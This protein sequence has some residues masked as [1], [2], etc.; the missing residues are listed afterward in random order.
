[1]KQMLKAIGLL[2]LMS[3]LAACGDLAGQ[4]EI[5]GQMP[6]AVPQDLNLEIPTTEPDLALGAQVFAENCTRCHG[7]TGAGDGEFV[8][9]GQVTEIPIFADPAQHIGRTAAE[10]FTTISLGR[11]E[12]LMP[13][14]ANSLTVEERWSVAN[15]VFTLAGAVAPLPE[16]TESAVTSST[17]PEATAEP[18]QTAI[19]TINGVVTNGTAGGTIPFGSELTLRVLNMLGGES[20]YSTTVNAD[21]SYQF[22][23]VEISETSAYRV[24]IE[25]AGGTFSS[26]IVVGTPELPNMILDTI[27]YETTDDPTVLQVNVVL[28]QIDM[29]A[30]DSLQVWQMINVTNTSDKLFIG[31]N[32]AGRRVSV[33]VPVPAG[34][35]LSPANDL[36]RFSFDST[37]QYIYDTRP[38]VP[39]TE[40]NFH[41]I[42]TVPFDGS[43]TVNQLF[44]YAFT[45]PYEVYVDSEKLSLSADGWQDLGTQTIESFTYKGMGLIDGAATG[46]TL[47][48]NVN[49]TAF[50]IDRNMIGYGLMLLGVLFIVG[51]SVMYWRGR[52]QPQTSPAVATTGAPT[53]Q[54]AILQAIVALDEKFEAKQISKKVY[55]RERQKLKNQLKTVMKDGQ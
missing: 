37:A 28:T 24:S 1:M 47:Q 40:H 2:L 26:E 7:I 41:L 33:R 44:D 32:D 13:P 53:G 16:T 14:F 54:E 35:S 52:N 23:N 17:N 10:Y 39:F 20:S 19:G 6:T 8:L 27:I 15:Y 45:G 36:D 42:Y 3:F 50:P 43:V 31:Q 30:S 25:Y 51:A 46:M 48:F 18:H 12:K 49:S 38:V 29:V 21:G 34:F 4:P 22:A 5:I 9:S 11:M 55:E